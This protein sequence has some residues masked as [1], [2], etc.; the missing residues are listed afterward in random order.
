M[1]YTQ[2]EKLPH[3][4]NWEKLHEKV[5]RTVETPLGQER[6]VMI[7]GLWDA[8]DWFEDRGFKPKALF[9]HCYDVHPE[10][11]LAYAMNWLLNTIFVER[12][13]QG[14]PNPRWIIAAELPPGMELFY[15]PPGL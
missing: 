13:R 8:L 14:L 15:R 2:R 3:W 4:E 6:I 11:D 9:K 1:H 12:E 7:R 5:G 10:L